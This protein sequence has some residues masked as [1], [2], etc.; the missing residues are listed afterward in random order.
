MH[1]RTAIG[2]GVS[3]IAAQGTAAK[4]VPLRAIGK[5]RQIKLK[6]EDRETNKKEAKEKMCNG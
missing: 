4:R 2:W 6:K 3:K 5:K 1:T